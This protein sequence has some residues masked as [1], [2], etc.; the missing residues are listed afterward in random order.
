MSRRRSREKQLQ[1]MGKHALDRLE[2][3][4]DSEAGTVAIAAIK[5]VLGMPETEPQEESHWFK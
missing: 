3:L 1:D 4:I 2:E 5:V